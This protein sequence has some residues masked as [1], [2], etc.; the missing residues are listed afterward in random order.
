MSY[1]ACK[2][3]M[4]PELRGMRAER[5]FATSQSLVVEYRAFRGHEAH[6]TVRSEVRLRFSCHASEISR[7]CSADR[8]LE[9][10][11]PFHQRGAVAR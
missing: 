8:I 9:L 1:V 6:R 4:P 10:G 11:H 5:F 3:A 7:E 2:L